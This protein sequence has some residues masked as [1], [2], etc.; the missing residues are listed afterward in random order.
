MSLLHHCC[1]ACVQILHRCTG[2]IFMDITSTNFRWL[3]Y[4]VENKSNRTLWPAL[5]VLP[6]HSLVS[7][8]R[9]KYFMALGHFKKWENWCLRVL[10]KNIQNPVDV[11][12][13]SDSCNQHI[14]LHLHIFHNVTISLVHAAWDVFGEE[15][16]CDWPQLK[17]LYMVLSFIKQRREW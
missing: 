14:W 7:M 5:S 9:L 8:T 17:E 10:A 12:P 16:Y 4:L 15:Q 1:R 11:H 6:L 13:N 2:T 3:I